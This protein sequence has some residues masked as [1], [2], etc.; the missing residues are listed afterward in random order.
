MKP[1][2]SFSESTSFVSHLS[3]PVFMSIAMS[4]PSSVPM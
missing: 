1:T 3:S 4:L 2:V